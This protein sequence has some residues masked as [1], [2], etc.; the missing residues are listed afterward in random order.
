MLA[1]ERRRGVL[2]PPRDRRT[3]SSARTSALKLRF[4]SCISCRVKAKGLGPEGLGVNDDRPGV[5]MAAVGT[6]EFRMSSPARGTVRVHGETN[7]L[8]EPAPSSPS[9]SSL[10]TGPVDLVLLFLAAGDRT[11]PTPPIRRGDPPPSPAR[12]I[13]SPA[14]SLTRGADEKRAAAVNGDS[15]RCAISLSACVSSEAER[16]DAAPRRRMWD[17]LRPRCPDAINASTER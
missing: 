5:P 11:A 14:V 15:P 12:H 10:P 7:W 16:A 4:S 17:L 3:R 1:R 9:L 13:P 8:S 6:D 2:P